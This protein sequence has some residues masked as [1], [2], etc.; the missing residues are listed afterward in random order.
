[1]CYLCVARG[2]VGTNYAATQ[3]S[4]KLALATWRTHPGSDNGGLRPRINR[5][6][7]TTPRNRTWDRSQLSLWGTRRRD[8]WAQLR[9]EIVG[10]HA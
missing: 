6:L 7:T 1:M 2:V 8:S 3:K 10:D 4:I 5:D 9:R